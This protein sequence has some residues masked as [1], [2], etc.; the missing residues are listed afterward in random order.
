MEALAA[1]VAPLLAVRAIESHP[2]EGATK[3]LTLDNLYMVCE[4]VE[5]LHHGG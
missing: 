2:L 3:I 4:S 5:A 1:A